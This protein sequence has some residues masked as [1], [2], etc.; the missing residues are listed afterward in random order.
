MSQKPKQNTVIKNLFSL[1]GT[2]ASGE[3]DFAD[4]REDIIKSIQAKQPD[5]E[6]LYDLAV[7]HPLPHAPFPC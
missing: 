1:G 5:I 4:T 6:V 3:K 7:I 2:A